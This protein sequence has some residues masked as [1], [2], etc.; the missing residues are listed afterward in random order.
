VSSLVSRRTQREPHST[1]GDAAGYRLISSHSVGGQL[2]APAFAC[3]PAPLVYISHH[4]QA[5]PK[6]AH[7]QPSRRVLAARWQGVLATML[8]KHDDASEQLIP[9][10]L[11]I[12]QCN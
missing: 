5:Q 11:V 1:V 9:P 12:R 6:P 10:E 4:R 2:R 3:L 7:L 8:G